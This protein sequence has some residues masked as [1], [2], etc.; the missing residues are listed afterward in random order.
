[1]NKTDNAGKP[2]DL[3]HDSYSKGSNKCW[4]HENGFCRKGRYSRLLHPKQICQVYSRSGQCSFG[5]VCQKRHPLKICFNYTK[6]LCKFGKKCV[7]QHPE[8]KNVP[9]SNI[10]PSVSTSFSAQGSHSLY[11]PW[12]VGWPAP[13]YQHQGWLG[14]SSSSQQPPAQ[15]HFR[16]GDGTS[17][18]Q[19]S[20]TDQPRHGGGQY[21]R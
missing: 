17:N 4:F 21:F 18:F 13:S 10:N 16:T 20:Q 11:L 6:N 2:L 9:S 5:M 7:Y 19:F 14:A 12:S 8:T 15:F 3:N 1:M